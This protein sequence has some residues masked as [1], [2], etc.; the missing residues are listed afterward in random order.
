MYFIPEKGYH[1]RILGSQD[2]VNGNGSF[3]NYGIY[4]ESISLNDISN[5]FYHQTHEDSPGIPDFPDACL[6]FMNDILMEEDLDGRLANLQD[7]HALQATEKSFYDAL[8]ETYPPSVDQTPSSFGGTTEASG[9][10]N[11]SCYAASVESN[12]LI[13]HSQSEGFQQADDTYPYVLE[14]TSECS[15]SSS[16]FNCLRDGLADSPV[17]TLFDNELSYVV[18]SGMSRA[19]K[20]KNSKDIEGQDEKRE[21]V[22]N[23]NVSKGRKNHQRESSS[24]LEERSAKQVASSNEEYAVMEKFDDVL[25]SKTGNDDISPGISKIAVNEARE[26]IQKDENPKGSKSKR[27]SSRGKKKTNREVVDLRT[28]LIQCAEA[29][30]ICDFATANELLKQIRQHA[31]PFGDSVQRVAHH[32]ANGLEARMTGTG[33]DLYKASDWKRFS[34]SDILKGYRLYVSAVPFQRT[35]YFLANQTIAKLAEKAPKIH[36]VDFGIFFGFQWP[37]LIQTLA[38]RPL[39]PPRLKITGIDNPRSGFRPAQTIEETGRRLAGYCE[40]FGVPFEFQAIAQHWHTVSPKDVNIERDELVVVSCFYQSKRLP[41]ETVDVNSPRDSFL[42]L[43]RS[44]NPD[45]FIHGVINGTFNASFFVTRFRE[46]L[47]HYSSLFDVFEATMLNEDRERQL[48]EN[49]LYGKDAMNIVACEGS[50]RIER[51][52]TYKQWNVRHQ[53]A[54]F[55]QVPLDQG[56]INRARAMVRANYHKDFMLEED[57]HWMVQG[58]KGRIFSAI[59]CWKPA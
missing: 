5:D 25:I 21:E 12:R 35:T 33:S 23:G 11:N 15:G 9:D 57:K 2:C 56:I 22:D 45:L 8:G 31:T 40:R 28:L 30:G 41:D 26:D 20:E 55:M 7:Y 53:R 44:L 14:S 49:Y 6:K 27:R 17:S 48:I 3:Q 46:A 58:W 47:Y 34:P 50:E 29:V 54:G 24:Y 19:Y 43:V 13:H 52:E 38:S 32:F 18:N 1:P 16:S 37:C 51:P 39:G 4:E 42:R 10:L 59:T 36:I